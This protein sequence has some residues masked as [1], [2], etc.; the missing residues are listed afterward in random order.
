MRRFISAS[1]RWLAA[2]GLALTLGLAAPALADDLGDGEGPQPPALRRPEPGPTTSPATTTPAASGAP[3][4]VAAA[5]GAQ[6]QP[7]GADARPK[8][9]SGTGTGAIHQHQPSDGI[10]PLLDYSGGL[11][12]RSA[13][14]GDW[15]GSRERLAEHGV[16]FD[17]SLTT[18]LQSVVSGGAERETNVGTSLDLGVHVDFMRMGLIPGGLLTLR[19][20]G[21]FGKSVL[22]QAGTI[23]GV[24]YNALMPIGTL[25]NDTATLSNLYYTQF[26]G[27]KFGVFAGRFDTF[28]DGFVMEFAGAGPGAGERGFLNA[29]LVAPQMVG[30]TTPYVTAFG[31][32]ILAKPNDT[33]SFS[34]MVMDKRES[35]L[36]DGLDSLGDDGWNALIGGMAQYKLAGLPG[37]AQVAGS[38]VWDGDFTDIGGGQLLNLRA[39]A[40]LAG[41][42]KSWNVVGNVWQYVQVFEDVSERSLDLHDG[43]PD[44]RGWGVFLMWGVADQD[45]NPFQWSFSGGV[46]GKGLIPGREEDVFGIGYFYNELEQGGVVDRTQNLRDGEQGFE[47]YYE[48]EV[49]PWLH[50][51]PDLQ[52]VRPG[53]G[54]NDTAVVLGLRALIDF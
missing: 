32:G 25:A 15:G 20:E 27:K 7:V 31:G 16:S 46:G 51:T 50:L 13:L 37:G 52:V 29:N 39:G 53:L 40:G 54:D 12:S 21:D 26:L 43:R 9:R 23:T 33:F 36:T 48:A 10:L 1:G 6:A 4:V 49:T 28:H 30:I 5:G 42:D 8:R 35:S 3:A 34:A 14:T 47:I 45:T 38:F 19:V 22:E 11:G 17:M 44:L 18:T 24:N 41:E 2:L